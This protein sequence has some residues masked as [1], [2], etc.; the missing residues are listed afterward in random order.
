MTIGVL[1]EPPMRL[2][3]ASNGTAQSGDGCAGEDHFTEPRASDLAASERV[4]RYKVRGM[5]IGKETEPRV[6]AEVYEEQADVIMYSPGD[7]VKFDII[8]INSAGESAPSEPVTV[9]FPLARGGV[10][11]TK[12][13]KTVEGPSVEAA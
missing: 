8:A 10:S 9:T 7:Q 11:L 2:S 12:S 1:Q 6:I 5:I 13:P 4:V 3:V